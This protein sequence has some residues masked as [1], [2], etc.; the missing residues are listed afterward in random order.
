MHG[1][2]EVHLCL[3]GKKAEYIGIDAGR[4]G[5]RVVESGGSLIVTIFFSEVGSKVISLV[6]ALLSK[7]IKDPIIFSLVQL[8]IL[9]SK[10]PTLIQIF[11]LCPTIDILLK[12]KYNHIILLLQPS[13]VFPSY[14]DKSQSCCFLPTF[15]L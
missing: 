3:K 6:L 12:S 14:S 8:P 2:W 5:N 1:A 9:W 4:W 15:L 10:L 7:Y 11:G 13:N